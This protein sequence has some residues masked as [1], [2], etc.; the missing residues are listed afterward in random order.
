MAFDTAPLANDRRTLRDYTSLHV[1]SA[2]SLQL[3]RFEAATSTLVPSACRRWRMS[4]DA[5]EH[6]F[7]IAASDEL[8]AAKL[9][10]D[11]ERG[12]TAA[13]DAGAPAGRRFHTISDLG[14][15]VSAED[16]AELFIR[17]TQPD[18]KVGHKLA[19]PSFAAESAQ[20]PFR[21]QDRGPHGG[22]LVK[23]SGWG[24]KEYLEL[25]YRVFNAP[26]AA[27]DAYEA[28]EVDATCPVL[29]SVAT[30]D[31]MLGRRDLVRGRSNTFMVLFPV[32]PIALQITTR[33]ALRDRLGISELTEPFAPGLSPVGGFSGFSKS[34]ISR[35]RLGASADLRANV[36]HTRP[37]TLSFDPFPPNREVLEAVGERWPGGVTLVADDFAAPSA[38]CDF[39]LVVLVNS[40]AYEADA[41]RMVG[42]TTAVRADPDLDGKWWQQIALY[43]AADNE[44]DR[45][46]AI[47]ILDE[48]LAEACPAIL[49]ARLN[50][51]HLQRPPLGWLDFA[52]DISWERSK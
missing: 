6:V 40:Y 30:L 46:G 17:L 8:S 18:R 11:F 34:K 19:H 43:D 23:Q 20:G 1:Y 7:Q 37:L 14:A 42:Q 52:S 2:A 27:M 25:E 33:R 10:A 3:F 38:P 9:A 49:L 16:D 50:A 39:R 47:A 5:T 41:Y 22:R 44:K 29:H 36:I 48:L 45:A 13:I 28:G 12:V 21:W 51:F 26:D 24:T 15:R 32:S 31:R 35:Q 4:A